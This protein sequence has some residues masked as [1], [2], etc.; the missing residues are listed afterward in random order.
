MITRRAERAVLDA[1]LPLRI[2]PL[3]YSHCWDEA[4]LPRNARCLVD[5]RVNYDEFNSRPP[6]LPVL[7]A[8]REFSVV[9]TFRYAT[10]FGYDSQL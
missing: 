2:V 8:H 5:G 4:V 3:A 6:V 9:Q 1:A 10:V 7:H